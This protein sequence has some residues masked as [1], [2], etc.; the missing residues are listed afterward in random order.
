MH[1][2]ERDCE[3]IIRYFDQDHDNGLNYK[4]FM[5]LILPCDDLVLRSIV[6]QRRS[7]VCMPHERL[8][9]YVEKELAKL[10][11]LEISY[12]QQVEMIKRDLQRRVDWC[13]K[14]AF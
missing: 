8:D 2:A 14:A 11:E 5:E 1:L 9:N 13:D 4:E 6:T 12:H 10:F 3:H 7:G